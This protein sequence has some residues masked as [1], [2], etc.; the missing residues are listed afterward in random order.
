[1]D[2]Y[3]S[4]PIQPDE[5]FRA[6]V[7]ATDAVREDTKMTGEPPIDLDFALT[8]VEGDMQLL[9]EI[10]GLFAEEC[11]RLMDSLRSALDASD[12]KAAESVA[13]TIK[14][15]LGNFGAKG[16]MEA[17]FTLE[18]FARQGDLQRSVTAY[19]NL[20]AAVELVRPFIAG[21]AQEE[22]A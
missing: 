6:L 7:R 18:Q 2:D 19:T 12:A 20:E 21:L 16:A 22:A 9:R 13:H 3:V 1:M 15:M 10:A 8:R 5:L 17:A 11:P 14:G 4:K